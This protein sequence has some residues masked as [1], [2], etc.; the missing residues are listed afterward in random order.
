MKRFRII[1]D[2]GFVGGQ[3]E[4]QAEFADE[5][6]D[7]L[8]EQERTDLLEEACQEAISNHIEA[9]WEEIQ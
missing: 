8:S 9:Y 5:A 7:G 2:T 3:H 6:W 1:V 4:E